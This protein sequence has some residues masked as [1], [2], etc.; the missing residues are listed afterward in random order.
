M[1]IWRTWIPCVGSLIV[2]MTIFGL[3]NNFGLIYQALVMEFHGSLAATGKQL[4][5]FYFPQQYRI[6]LLHSLKGF[7]C[8]LLSTFILKVD[9]SGKQAL[10]TWHK[11][12]RYS[13]RYC[14]PITW[15]S[16]LEFGFA[17]VLLSS[18]ATIPSMT[19]LWDAAS[20]FDSSV[21]MC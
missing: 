10:F 1:F 8:L 19:Y 4:H 13:L 16:D 3:H 9:I 11:M 15:T 2:Q 5:T 12:D 18:I 20:L 6:N 21:N 17:K 7:F 14:Q